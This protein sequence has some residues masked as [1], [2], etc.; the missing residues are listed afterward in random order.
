M[1][2]VV[3]VANCII[4]LENSRNIKIGRFCV[5]NAISQTFNCIRFGLDSEYY[6]KSIWEY[7]DI[8]TQYHT[9]K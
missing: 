9:R 1:I 3:L 6:A 7:R 8:N 5:Q 2:W 4:G